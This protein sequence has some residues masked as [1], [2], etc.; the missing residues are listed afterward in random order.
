[1]SQLNQMYIPFMTQK[2]KRTCT[3]AVAVVLWTYNS[4]LLFSHITKKTILLTLP[5]HISIS[6]I[7][8]NK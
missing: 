8:I 5:T 6:L 3:Y 4:L 7:K 2:A 1:M